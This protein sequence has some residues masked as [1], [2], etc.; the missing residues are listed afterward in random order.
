[1]NVLHI[2]GRE[3]RYIL[4]TVV[5]WIVLAAF[6]VIAGFFWSIYLSSYAQAASD[7][8]ANPYQLAQLSI[9]DHLLAP[10]FGNINVFLIF[11]TPALAMR[12][13]SEEVKQ[14]TIELLLTSPVSTWE[15]VLGKYLGA[16]G[17]VAIIL[18]FT[19]YVPLSLYLFAEPDP[20]AIVGGY[21]SLF[22]AAAVIMA[23]SMFLSAMTKN[24]LVAVVLG[25]SVALF[26]FVISWVDEAEDPDS[27]LVQLGLR[28][29]LD[30]LARGVFRLSDLTYVGAF[31]G[32]FLYAV[33]QRVDSFRWR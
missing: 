29:H 6:L 23:V 26:F 13:F 28:T 17:F 12:L 1:M 16:M 4:N 24:Q 5:G 8:L 22:L 32:F 7:M 20:A 31:V 18:A 3:L 9:T 19:S 15:I 30:D 27:I 11:F 33:H 2:A 21:L 25:I 10:F 14:R